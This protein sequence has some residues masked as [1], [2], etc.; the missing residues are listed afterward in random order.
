MTLDIDKITKAQ[1]AVVRANRERAAIGQTL[2]RS[3]K[4]TTQV[5]KPLRRVGIIVR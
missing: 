3:R 1:Q 5:A 2:A 4:V